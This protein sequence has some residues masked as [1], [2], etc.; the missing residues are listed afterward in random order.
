MPPKAQSNN[1]SFNKTEEEI[2]DFIDG[3][4]AGE[5]N[6][7]PD[8]A[9]GESGNEDEEDD[10]KDAGD[11]DA[12]G[13]EGEGEGDAGGKKAGGADKPGQKPAK[14]KDGAL[15]DK[16]TKQAVKPG[17]ERR[18]YEEAHHYKREADSW[19]GKHEQLLGEFNA[20]RG[21]VEK[22][23]SYRLAPDE[24]VE[25]ARIMDTYK[26]DPIQAI[27][28]IL[29]GAKEAGIDL[30]RLQLNTIDTNAIMSLIKKE[31]GARLDPIDQDRQQ[32]QRD[33]EAT[34]N[35][36]R[37]LDDFLYRNPE[38]EPHLSVIA[39]LMERHET[40]TLREA[41]LEI[42]DYSLRNGIDLSKPPASGS[43]QRSDQTSRKPIPS[44]GRGIVNGAGGQQ[45]SRQNKGGPAPVGTSLDDIIVSS[46][47][48]A[49]L[50][51]SR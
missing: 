42:R 19:K 21:A 49:G 11:D 30:S 31:V 16:K 46:M 8:P 40:M 27:A 20:Y 1:G 12:G 4:K 48:E 32:R 2:L 28:E 29:T 7:Q 15:V 26:R 44:G 22:T 35:A 37:D 50:N 43:A 33:A 39:N 14:G 10:G 18:Y 24:M 17:A 51:Y 45:P 38:A 41:W 34:T 13:D 6:K 3:G 9:E 5:D 25:A 23:N 36:T 47:R